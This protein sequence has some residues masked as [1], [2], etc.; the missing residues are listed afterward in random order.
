MGLIDKAKQLIRSKNGKSKSADG[1]ARLRTR[2]ITPIRGDYTLSNSELVFS[3][4]SRIANS[5]SAMPIQLYQGSKPL[6]NP[7]NDLVSKIP[8]PNMSGSRFIRTLETC[9]CTYGNGYALK[10]YDV[11][12]R[13]VRI[14]ILD[15]NRVTPLL[16]TDSGELW[17]RIATAPDDYPAGEFY[18]HNFNVIH[19]SFLNA[20]GYKG[21]NP[22]SVLYDTLKY[23][24]DIQQFSRK[25][26]E[27]GVNAAI[28]LEAPSNLGEPQK[29]AM[30]EKF[31][32]TYR[33][34][35]GNILLVES[36]V[37]VKSLNLSPVDSDL[38]EVERITRSKIAMIYNIPPH[39]LG[40]YSD[41]S[42]ASQEQQMLEFLMLTMLPIVTDYEQEFNRKLLSDKQRMSGMGF[43]F[44]MDSILRADSATMADVH[45]KGVRSGWITP[46]EIRREQGR[47]PLAN[48][49]GKHPLVS[50][51]LATLEYTVRDKPR[52]LMAKVD[53]GSSADDTSN[54]TPQE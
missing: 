2:N 3:A 48:G 37:T 42:F 52:V 20:N 19:V 28:V 44:N 39:L 32:D 29:A 26:L 33:K 13:L 53:G 31:M 7:L 46:D 34:T 50:Q 17:Y 49:I 21:I 11:G 25:Q 43:K 6:N 12:G 35:S 5:L 16:E 45:Y 15:P 18:V 40:D 1:L 54:N 10:I 9:R 30:I 23:N 27:Q 24:E 22:V 4:V 36:G 8:N 41:V 47:A 14:D 51:D 38:F